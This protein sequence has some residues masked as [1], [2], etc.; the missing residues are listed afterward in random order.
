M[1]MKALTL[2][3]LLVLGGVAF[4]YLGGAEKLGWIPA[5]DLPETIVPPNATFLGTEQSNPYTG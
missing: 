2:V 4:Y 1:I 5:K 3:V